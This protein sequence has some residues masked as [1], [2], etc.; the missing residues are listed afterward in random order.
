MKTLYFDCIGG[1]SGDMALAAL[2]DA[3][4]YIDAL[5]SDLAKLDLGEF[6]LTVERSAKSAIT[7]NHVTVTAPP[8]QGHG[9]HLSHIIEVI[10]GA[11]YPTR[12]R[13]RAAR[14]FTRLAEAEAVIHGT[15]IQKIHFHEVGAV[16]SIVDIVGC[17]LALEMLTVGHIYCSPLP[18][19]TGFVDCAHGR[20][21]LPA[22]ATLE[23]L[24][25]IPTVPAGYEGETVTPTGAAIVST[26]ADGFGPCPPLILDK[27]GYGI[28]TMDFPKPNILRVWLGRQGTLG[29]VD[30]DAVAV[31]ETSIDDMSPQFFE[32]VTA[33]LFAA[34]ALDA[35][36]TPI[37]MKKGRPAVLIT[38]I[39][40]AGAADKM[41]EILLQ[42]TT[43]LGVRVRTEQRTCLKR[44]FRTVETS[45]GAIR[46]KLAG[47]K[48]S[49]EYEDVKQAAARAGTSFREAHERIWIEVADHLKQG[50]TGSEAK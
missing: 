40:A 28:G 37:Q 46:V 29:E 43:T 15:D 19:G 42:S 12:V 20:M 3:G 32:P 6:A 16:D 11:G 30:S 25:G 23:L 50:G 31:L 5:R 24:K 44:E 27:V 39:C 34:G 49:I 26:L 10:D 4:A 48:W 14:I 9:R 36:I 35:Y 17:C 2:L 18:L 41:T 33:D 45:L 47:S 8:H 21:P 38:V 13:D 7:G 22:P 1:I